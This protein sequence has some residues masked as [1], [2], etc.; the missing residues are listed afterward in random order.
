MSSKPTEP[1]TERNA[2]LWIKAF[3]VFHII[4][5]TMWTL[6]NPKRPYLLGTAR[7]EVNA[8]S[9]SEFVRS[10]S[11][12][13][14]QGFLYFNWKYI[15]QSPLMY[16]AGSTGFWQFWDMFSPDPASVDLF[17]VADVTYKDGTVYRFNFPR[18]YSLPLHQKYL[19]ERYR[20]YFENVN[21]DDQ[22]FS[23]P[24]TAQRIALECFKDPNN[25]P[26]KVMLIR[27]S[28]KIAAPGQPQPAD[29]TKTPFFE[30]A[31]DQAKLL[32]DKGLTP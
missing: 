24:Y 26:I 3:V 16:Y 9:P 23:R 19:K 27:N 2:P 17:L 13:T 15:K 1:K 10:F 29:Y 11:E 5:I 25:P 20:K 32:K 7:F 21:S 12:T 22:A 8:Q 18:V 28:Y 6:P 14:T 4:G 31:V 30:Y